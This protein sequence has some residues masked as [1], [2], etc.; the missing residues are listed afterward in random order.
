MTTENLKAAK[1]A[2]AKIALVYAPAAPQ[3]VRKAVRA[4]LEYTRERLS[5]KDDGGARASGM[6][7]RDRILQ[8]AEGLPGVGMVKDALDK[9]EWAD[10]TPH[11]AM[12]VR[13]MLRFTSDGGPL[14]ARYPSLCAILQRYLS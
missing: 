8:E 5:D 11:E 3:P 1:E 12:G 6:R 14:R 10:Y 13:V 4:M 2:L 9:I 7:N